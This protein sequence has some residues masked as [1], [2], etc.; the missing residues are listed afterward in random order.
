M[1]KKA[2]KRRLRNANYSKATKLSTP[3]KSCDA[4]KLSSVKKSKSKK[5]VSSSRKK[6][7]VK[8][9]ETAVM[10]KLKSKSGSKTKRELSRRKRG[11]QRTKTKSVR[12]TKSLKKQTVLKKS[13][14]KKKSSKTTKIIINKIKPSSGT[15]RSMWTKLSPRGAKIKSPKT[16]T[17]LLKKFQ[18]IVRKAKKAS[19]SRKASKSSKKKWNNKK[20]YNT[21]LQTSPRKSSGSKTLKKNSSKKMPD[22]SQLSSKKKSQVNAKRKLPVTRSQTR[23]RKRQNKARVKKSRSTNVKKHEHRSTRGVGTGR[24]IDLTAHEVVID[25]TLSPKVALPTQKEDDPMVLN[26][27]R[28][29]SPKLKLQCPDSDGSVLASPAESKQPHSSPKPSSLSDLSPICAIKHQADAVTHSNEIASTPNGNDNVEKVHAPDTRTSRLENLVAF[30]VSE[31]SIS[32][33]EG[34]PGKSTIDEGKVRTSSS[35]GFGPSLS[36]LAGFWR[37]NVRQKQPSSVSS[38]ASTS[39]D[40]VDSLRHKKERETHVRSTEGQK[41]AIHRSGRMLSNKRIMSRSHSGF[42]KRMRRGSWS[43]GPTG[44]AKRGDSHISPLDFKSSSNKRTLSSRRKSGSIS[45]TPLKTIAGRIGFSGNKLKAP[46]SNFKNQEV[47]AKDETSTSPSNLLP[48][49]VSDR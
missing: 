33:N 14:S 18:K 42:Q 47:Q 34:L 4:S 40:T 7:L 45:I 29:P 23:V 48:T 25:L 41:R 19:R 30:V 8:P 13:S 36:T 22:L 31:R 17:P 1:A 37:K 26:P 20:R 35:V 9:A 15:G 2:K 44:N 10:K 6:K 32:T 43:S 49:L 39:E 11:G 12:K 16:Q 5:P 27:K 3:N 21:S 46:Y 24:V 28:I 38:T